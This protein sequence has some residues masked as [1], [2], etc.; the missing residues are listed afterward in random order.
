MLQGSV[1]LAFSPAYTISHLDYLAK[2]TNTKQTNS[3][4]LRQLAGAFYI[5]H[6]HSDFITLTHFLFLILKLQQSTKFT[7]Y[8]QG[9]ALGWK[10]LQEGSRSSNRNPFWLHVCSLSGL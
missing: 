9:V 2:T 5:C 4:C 6:F 1:F 8:G 7:N 10:V 3:V